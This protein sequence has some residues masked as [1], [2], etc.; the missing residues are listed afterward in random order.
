M[1]SVTETINRGV[2]L[3]QE[4]NPG[5]TVELYRRVLRRFPDHPEALHLLSVAVYQLGEPADVHSNLGRYYLSLGR[6]E[7]AVSELDRALALAPG[8]AQ[9]RF[10]VAV[11]LGNRK[12][13]DHITEYVK[14]KPED[15]GGHH[16]LGL[17]LSELGRAAEAVAPLL[18][19]RGAQ[20]RCR[21]GLQQ[22]G[23]R[24]ASDSGSPLW[25]STKI[26]TS[27]E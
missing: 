1:T 21:R 25:Q 7:E 2:V 10:N 26:G 16:Q 19:H 20:A 8:H 24:H 18:P 3:L 23:Q 9:A 6:L 11:A 12:R 13:L 27:R 22:P 14:L 17:T 15:P 5:R 4:G